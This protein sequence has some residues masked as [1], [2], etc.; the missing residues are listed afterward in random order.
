MGFWF[1]SFWFLVFEFLVVVDLDQML[2]MARSESAERRRV[3]RYVLKRWLECKVEQVVLGKE[4]SWRSNP[5]AQLCFHTLLSHRD[6]ASD[7]CNLQEA[8]GGSG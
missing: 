1:L 5:S 6:F 2:K 3:R 8:A 4:V 7:P